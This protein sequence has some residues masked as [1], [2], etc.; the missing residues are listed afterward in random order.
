MTTVL[1]ISR[2][3]NRMQGVINARV[4]KMWEAVDM[5]NGNVWAMNFV[6]L[7][8]EGGAI[9][10]I[11]PIN[12]Y[13]RMQRDF[14]EG[15]VCEI[16]RFTVEHVKKNGYLTVDHAF[17]L[18]FSGQTYVTP[19]SS[20]L[21][22][23]PTCYFVFKSLEDIGTKITEE[24]QPIDVIGFVSD[25]TQIEEKMVRG[26]RARMQ[27]V[28]IRNER[29]HTVQLT[30][31]SDFIDA[32]DIIGVHEKSNGEPVILACS[33]VLVKQYM[34]TFGL[35]AYAASRFYTDHK[36]REVK[37]FFERFNCNNTVNA[38]TPTEIDI[39]DC[40]PRVVRFK[41]EGPSIISLADLALLPL[42]NFSSG[43]YTCIVDIVGVNNPFDW[44]YEGCPKCNTKLKETFCSPC[45]GRKP[46]PSICY[47]LLLEVSDDT[48]TAEFKA[49]GRTAEGIVGQAA[50]V[51][52]GG[53]NMDSNEL[54]DPLIKMIGKK[55]KI[56]VSGK[57][58]VLY[59]DHRTYNILH[60][61]LVSVK[62]QLSLLPIHDDFGDELV[63]GDNTV[64]IE[65]DC[66]EA[67][68]DVT[69][70]LSSELNAMEDNG[71]KNLLKEVKQ[72][73]KNEVKKKVASS[74]DKDLK[75]KR[76]F[77]DAGGLPVCKKN[78]RRKLIISGQS[79]GETE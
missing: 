13:R 17:T 51:V 1:P 15:N 57:L 23:I 4:L 55:F 6:L 8:K 24:T 29:G 62:E 35:K 27:V 74:I 7:D 2:L 18:S 64:I 10:G 30:L 5:R 69:T 12:Y 11:M 37:D 71:S 72:E 45:K 48:G 36:I 59:K 22:D 66:N 49:V 34:G 79:D 53:M 54:P 9:Q 52:K 44:Y 43:Q 31:W 40:S 38:K 42:D 25:F 76:P 46:D 61:E 21:R 70:S 26:T 16:G 73:F 67:N 63:K 58:Q 47:R 33:S 32:L 77:D 78:P 39:I 56:T 68:N 75:G 14:V 19:V 3:T 28:S 60:T 50:S 41:K 65:D 20:N